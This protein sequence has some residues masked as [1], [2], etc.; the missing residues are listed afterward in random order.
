[1]IIHEVALVLQLPTPLGF[2]DLRE[3]RLLRNLGRGRARD[4][5]IFVFV[6]LERASGGYQFPEGKN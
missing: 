4:D 6:V 2:A 5:P 3:Q 1:M